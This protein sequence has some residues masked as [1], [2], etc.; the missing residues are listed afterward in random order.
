MNMEKSTK[1][2]FAILAADDVIFRYKDGLLEVLLTK[3]RQSSPF[4]GSLSLPGGLIKPEETAEA[5]GQRIAE[6]KGG[7]ATGAI[8]Y[9]EQLFTFSRVDRD[10][11]GRVISV[12]FLM[13][14]KQADHS[15][16]TDGSKHFWYPAFHVPKLAYDHNQIIE[17]ALQRLISKL[18]YTN[19]A[20]YLLPE[21]F[22]MAELQKLYEKILEK[23]FD[24]RNFRKKLFVSR[25]VV[26]TKYSTS[27][28]KHRPARLYKFLGGGLETV[29]MV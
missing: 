25:I 29:S 12:A 21:V 14:F 7:L 9:S 4:P 11:R 24:K 17:K 26:Q 1:L 13:L 23:K 15:I 3:T 8:K 20:R 27:G 5:A 28:G 19:I 2:K 6:E 16:E 22:T 18:E 10:P